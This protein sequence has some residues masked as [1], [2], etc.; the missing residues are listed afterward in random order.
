M[1]FTG[2]R[3]KPLFILNTNREALKTYIGM[4]YGKIAAGEN[5]QT[6]PKVFLTDDQENVKSDPFGKTAYY[7]PSNDV[8]RV[9]VTGRLMIDILRSFSHECI[10]YA[11]KQ[12]GEFANM[13]GAGEGYAQKDPHLRK[14]EEEAYLKGNL[15]LRDF[16]DE[17]RNKLKGQ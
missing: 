10:H 14:M 4:L 6:P 1:D 3:N 16:Q 7:D 11:Q 5:L 9:Y 13:Q 17:M 15:Y 12:R 2:E 8:I